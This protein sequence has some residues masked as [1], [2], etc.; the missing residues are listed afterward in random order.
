MS[1]FFWVN[2]LRYEFLKLSPK[3]MNRLLQ[4]CDL[5]P[6]YIC[7]TAGLFLSYSLFWD[8]PT[9]GET[10]LQTCLIMCCCY[11]SSFTTLHADLW[12]LC[13]I[14]CFGQ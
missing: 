10:T 11:Q 2:K 5:Q 12:L 14:L 6:L 4:K 3:N 13:F 9:F 7:P 8:N 1:F